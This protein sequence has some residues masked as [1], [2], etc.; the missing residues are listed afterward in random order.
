[1][2]TNEAGPR[3]G[4]GRLTMRTRLDAAKDGAVAALQVEAPT[5]RPRHRL[6]GWLSRRPTT[7]GCRPRSPSKPLRWPSCEKSG[8]TGAAA[9]RSPG[10]DEVHHRVQKLGGGL[11]GAAAARSPGGF[12]AM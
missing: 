9:A 4:E 11:T 12:Q 2:A 10:V 3:A 1:M 6:R 5:S 8:L 7:P